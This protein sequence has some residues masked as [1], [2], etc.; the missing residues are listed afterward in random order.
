MGLP[1]RRLGTK[2]NEMRKT[3]PHCARVTLH[4]IN[5]PQLPSILQSPAVIDHMASSV[6]DLSDLS[7]GSSSVSADDAYQFLTA[8]GFLYLEDAEVGKL[9]DELYNSRQ[10]RTEV[11]SLDYFMPIL[12]NNPVSNIQ[13]RFLCYYLQL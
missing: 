4:V 5:T 2:L 3:L 10:I 11:A 1:G 8:H 9:V 6:Q 13:N 12:E 7:R